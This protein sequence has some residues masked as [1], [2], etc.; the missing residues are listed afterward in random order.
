MASRNF[1]WRTTLYIEVA[2]TLDTHSASESSCISA[3]CSSYN[4]TFRR[5]DL[6]LLSGETYGSDNPR[7]VWKTEL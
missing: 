6:F 1:Q 4:T 2:F 7:C 3:I 5:R